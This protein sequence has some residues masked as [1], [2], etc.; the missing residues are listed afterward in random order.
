MCE[1]CLGRS[2]TRRR[3]LAVTGA[4]VAAGLLLP[5]I[6]AAQSTSEAPSTP[7]GEG[8]VILPRDVWG[9]DLPPKGP[10]ESE[11]PGDVRFLLVHHSASANDYSEEQSTQLLRS[12]YHYHTSAEKGWPD[13]AYNFLVDRH[14]QISRGV[15]E[16]SHPPCEA[17]ATGGSQG[18]A[19]LCCFI[20]DHRDVAPTGAAQSAMIALLAWLSKTY[21]IDPSPGSTVEFVSRGS[22]LHPRGTAVTSPTITG[23]RTMSRTTCP[24]DAAFALVEGSF[25]TQV[26]AAV[27]GAA[28]APSG[29]ENS[30]ATGEPDPAA[31]SPAPTTTASHPT[32]SSNGTTTSASDSATSEQSAT[33]SVPEPN[34]RAAP[35]PDTALGPS[36]AA[37]AV[38]AAPA[39]TTSLEASQNGSQPALAEAST[40]TAPAL[41]SSKNPETGSE[42]A[43]APAGPRSGLREQTV[44]WGLAVAV[45]A[46]GI[47]LLWPAIWLSR[48]VAAT[49]NREQVPAPTASR[50]QDARGYDH[51]A[52]RQHGDVEWRD[53]EAQ[54]GAGP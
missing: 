50:A 27:A 1:Q 13:L 48:R 36:D 2:L 28:P 34:S 42:A 47:A 26:N 54:P 9:A 39:T 20:G 7:I 18:F 37:A 33:P 15:R 31:S 17:D 5:E 32:D 4:G 43:A 24:G 41:P 25:P 11:E 52:R 45:G 3:F 29:L 44:R 12:F 14:G 40:T 38:S 6:S 46:S 10:M 22:N 16:A 35:P 8:H 49:L 21:D 19:L 53:H 30:P 51:S 23:H